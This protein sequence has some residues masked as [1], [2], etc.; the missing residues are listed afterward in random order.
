MT[1]IANNL[2]RIRAELAEAAT[3]AGRNPDA[4]Q[5]LAVSKTKPAEMVIEAMDANQQHFGENTIQDAQTKIPLLID[6]KPTWHFIGHLQTNKAKFIPGQFQWLHT[7]DNLELARKLSSRL[8]KANENL[9]TL[10]QVNV[11]QDEHKHGLMPDAVD[12]FMDQLMSAQ[13]PGLQLRGLMTIGLQS[14]DTNELRKGFSD[15]RELRDRLASR[16]DL[17]QFDQ[18]SMGMSGDYREAIAEGATWVRIGSAIFGSR[19]K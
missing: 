14:H 17:P 5:L 3:A 7:L 10:I 1:T 16:F 4:V 13:L 8:D 12:A 6:R 2:K 19:N 18:L 9:N 15:L 11:T